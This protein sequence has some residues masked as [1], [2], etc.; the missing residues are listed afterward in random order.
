MS[1]DYAAAVFRVEVSGV[2]FT[3][4]FFI[5]LCS[6]LPFIIVSLDPQKLFF[7]IIISFGNEAV[8][9]VLKNLS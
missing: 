9:S 1:A 8:S 5:T 3:L 6:P 2:C 4:L 7:G